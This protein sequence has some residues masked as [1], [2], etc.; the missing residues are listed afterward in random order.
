METKIVHTHAKWV[1]NSGECIVIN[2]SPKQLTK[3]TGK[4]DMNL[5]P[6]KKY[7]NSYNCNLQHN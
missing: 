3:V 5:L 2:N 7:G 6:I 1:C 4:K